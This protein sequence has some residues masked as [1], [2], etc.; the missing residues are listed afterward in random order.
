MLSIYA[1]LSSR[2]LAVQ[3]RGSGCTYAGNCVYLSKIKNF[4]Y[5]QCQYVDELSSLI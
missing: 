5:I 3:K 2:R 1:K 4:Y